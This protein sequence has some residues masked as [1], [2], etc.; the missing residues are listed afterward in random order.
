M[1]TTKVAQ[2]LFVTVPWLWK[3]LKGPDFCPGI[4][5]C[6]VRDDVPLPFLV[7]RLGFP[8]PK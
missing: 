5:Q 2:G 7:F 4:L 1:D 6:G 8:H 3:W